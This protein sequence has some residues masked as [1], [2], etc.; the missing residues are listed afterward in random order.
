[1][2]A[3]RQAAIGA[4]AVVKRLNLP[5]KPDRSSGFHG[6]GM[7]KHRAMLRFVAAEWE[8]FVEALGDNET[9]LAALGVERKDFFD[10]FSTDL[11][12]SGAM[13]DFA[14]Q[15]LD[16]SSTGTS[17][18]AIRFV[19]RCRPRSGFLRELCLRGLT[20]KGSS[21]WDSFSTS[22]TAGEIIGR[23]FSGDTEL[24]DQLVATASADIHNPGAIIALCE[25]W[26]DSKGFRALRS[27]FEPQQQSVPILLRLSRSWPR[28]IAS[29][30]RLAGPR[31]IWK[32]ICGIAYQTGCQR[33][34]AD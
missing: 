17:A 28:R 29:L 4:L 34:F 13:T 5:A 24:E 30:I 9:A 32:E 20:F 14:L 11:N 8:T 22:L 21:N 15:M 6:I 3:R 18:A 26:P 25:G 12:A 16:S 23:N 19:E 33:Q 2:D 27:R 10:V 7:R 31:I 1:M